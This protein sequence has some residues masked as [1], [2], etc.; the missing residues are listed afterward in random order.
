MNERVISLLRLIEF[1][2]SALPVGTFSFSCGLETAAERGLVTNAATLE[3]YARTM[4][5]QTAFTDGVAAL[6]AY[7]AAAADDLNAVIEADTRVWCSKAGAENR[8][9]TQ[10]MGRKLTELALK[11]IGDDRL[12]AWSGAV[13]AERT[14]GCW[15]VA[16]G[17]LFAAAGMDAP[18]LFAAHMYGTASMILN[19]ALRCVRVSHFDTQAILFRLCE[20]IGP[21][22]CEVRELTI[23]DMNLFTPEADILAA[24][25][26]R[27]PM[28][29][30]M[31]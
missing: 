21:L 29:M 25:H 7:R 15:P 10:R 2:D 8:L 12:A 11:L 20:H 19:A 17:V 4:V 16:Q 5:V 31:N 30:F 6:C 13:A 28:R 24:L 1:S 14:P 3:E 26:E 9:M 22:Y 27:G 18:S 23:D